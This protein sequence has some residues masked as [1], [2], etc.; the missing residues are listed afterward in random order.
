MQAFHRAQGSVLV[1][2]HSNA[3]SRSDCR[4]FRN[5]TNAEV[6]A[7]GTVALLPK[8]ERGAN[9]KVRAACAK[10]R[11]ADEAQIMAGFGDFA[12]LI[13]GALASEAT[14]LLAPPKMSP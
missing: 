8:K 9:R 6:A 11:S 5:L 3:E 1:L 2:E 10:C 4:N 13:T 12:G 14:G 7:T